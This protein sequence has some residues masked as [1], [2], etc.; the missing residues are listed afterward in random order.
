VL[1]GGHIRLWSVVYDEE[2]RSGEPFVAECRKGHAHAAPE[3][4]CSCGVYALRE[5]EEL[6]RYL[7]GRDD[8]WVV[9]R[10]IGQVELW[11]DVVEGELGWRAAY[12]YPRRIELASSAG[13]TAPVV[14]S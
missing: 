10:V 14:S 4:D 1:L 3:A 5:P 9:G 7:V 6:T 2:W 8:P 11:G 13:S 12:A